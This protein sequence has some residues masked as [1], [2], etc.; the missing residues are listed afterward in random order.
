MDR[1]TDHRLLV[2]GAPEK[3]T[4]TRSIIRAD[5]A[6]PDKPPSRPAANRPSRRRE[7]DVDAARSRH[8]L[9]ARYLR[10]YGVIATFKTPSRW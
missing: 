1:S 10:G 3:S 7:I 9:D 4:M 6:A 2:G 5:L 8:G